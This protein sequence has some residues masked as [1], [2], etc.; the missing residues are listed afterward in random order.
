MNLSSS[1]WLG[2]VPLILALAFHV[3]VLQNGYGWDDELIIGLL[4]GDLS[5]ARILKSFIPNLD[6]SD[7][8][9]DFHSYY[10]P[11]VGLSYRLD[12]LVW[13]RNPMG[14]HF[15]V[16]LAH[17]LNAALVFLLTRRLLLAGQARGPGE[18]KVRPPTFAPLI[19]ASLFAVHPIHTEAV[20]WIAGRNDVF[21]TTFLLVSFLLYARF[22]RVGNIGFA[23]FAI[24]FY[25]LALLTKEM[26]A[27]FFLLFPLYSYLA[28][29]PMRGPDS[30][31]KIGDS[32]ARRLAVGMGIPAL[33]LG[34]YFWIR[35]T[36][37]LTPIGRPV[38]SDYLSLSSARSAMAAVGLYL[39]QMLIPYPHA[40]FIAALPSS[41]WFLSFSAIASVMMGGGFILA[42]RRRHLLFGIGLGWMILT[43]APAVAVTVMDVA[44]AAAAERYVY[45]PSIGLLM[46]AVGLVLEGKG[47]LEKRAFPMRKA[48]AIAWIA[49][50]VLIGLWGWESWQR[51]TVWR[52]PFTFWKAAV[53]AAPTAGFP[54]RVLGEEYIRRENFAEAESHLLRA[55]ELEEKNRGPYDVEV[56]LTLHYL[57]EFYFDH[58]RY[59]DVEPLYLRE[60]EI[61][62]TSRGEVHP[63]IATTLNNLA[64][65]R[66][67]QGRADEA[68]SLLRQALEVWRKVPGPKKAEIA[69][70]LSNLAFVLS[71]QDKNPEAEKIYRQSIELREEDPGPDPPGLAATL[72]DYAKLLR[73]ME[74]HDEAV[75]IEVRADRIG[76]KATQEH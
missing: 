18:H 15:S 10:R 67:L 25:L 7:E 49:V 38:L 51:N 72:R 59:R 8:S 21:C 29:P 56:A 63:S 50:M 3:N 35:S 2:L 28:R 26:A 46:V 62:R 11:V 34:F 39:K 70:T 58:G 61:W 42:L 52:D 41:G 32:L 53:A 60:L 16:W 36:R 12:L 40:P 47:A 9:K 14:F 68:E 57:A 22:V 17:G 20:A 33:L 64:D 5:P 45:A 66:Y 1:K 4:D 76:K 65:I 55:V 30:P 74:R 54:H 44:R 48:P 6:P 43:L 31:W 13:G 69:Q 19:A 27:F 73:K 23:L 24:F 75:R 71:A 37:L